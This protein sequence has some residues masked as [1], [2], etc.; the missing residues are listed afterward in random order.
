MVLPKLK[1][2]FKCSTY[3]EIKIKILEIIHQ[4]RLLLQ[5]ILQHRAFSLLS[6]RRKQINQRG[7]PA[8]AAIMWCLVEEI[9]I[10]CEERWNEDIITEVRPFREAVTGLIG[11]IHVYFTVTP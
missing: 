4:G 1:V 10:C 9:R 7:S 6:M 2:C 11:E 3:N 8:R 5:R